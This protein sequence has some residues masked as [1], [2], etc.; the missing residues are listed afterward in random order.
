MSLLVEDWR[1]TLQL[2]QE[3]RAGQWPEPL[4]GPGLAPMEPVFA[5]HP[6]RLEQLVGLQLAFHESKPGSHAA[7][8]RWETVGEG[9]A[10]LTPQRVVVRIGTDI[11]LGWVGLSAVYGEHEGLHFEYR[12]IPQSLHYRLRLEYPMWWTT[13][14]RAVAFGQLHDEQP[15]DWILRQ[16]GR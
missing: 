7:A 15:P 13:M 1:A 2:Q 12:T 4:P 14:L 16:L 6:A 10:V 5:H 9:T 11:S 3:I 8:Q